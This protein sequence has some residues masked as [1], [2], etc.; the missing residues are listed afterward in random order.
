MKKFDLTGRDPVRNTQR[1]IERLHA[2]LSFSGQTEAARKVLEA[3]KHVEQ[4]VK[5]IESRYDF[6]HVNDTI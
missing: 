1:K 6:S 5:F 3:S 2:E 4:E